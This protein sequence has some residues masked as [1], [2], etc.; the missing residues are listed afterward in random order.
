[1]L[2]E[3]F[4]GVFKRFDSRRNR[5]SDQRTDFIFVEQR[6]AQAFV[7]LHDATFGIE[8]ERSRKRGDTTILH[9]DLVGDH[10]DR[11]VDTKFLDELFYFGGVVVIDIEAD[12]LQF[13][14]VFFLE[15]DQIGNF[16]AA[17]SAPG[18]PEIE[19]DDFAVR[20]GER[21][22][23]AVDVVEFEV[24]RLVGIADEADDGAGIRASRGGL[25][26]GESR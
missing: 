7:F 20:R 11:V 4:A 19:K 13:V 18:R 17:W 6:I 1:M 8:N 25:L 10:G 23:L 9:A 15:L 21:K 26:S 5:Q 3:N 12:D 16:G 14:R 22:R 2:Q 24:G